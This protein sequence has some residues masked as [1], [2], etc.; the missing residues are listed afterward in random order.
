[1]LTVT[2][3]P[4]RSW[5][6]LHSQD[7]FVLI[8]ALLGIEPRSTDH[9]GLLKVWFSHTRGVIS[10]GPPPLPSFEEMLRY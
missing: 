8:T 1:M 10:A 4:D 5:T 3:V 6:I 7:T 2:P 9:R